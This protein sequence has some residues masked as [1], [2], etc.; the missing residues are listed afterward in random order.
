MNKKNLALIIGGSI[1]SVIVGALLRKQQEEDRLRSNEL[2]QTTTED[3]FNK[4]FE[5]DREKLRQMGQY[6]DERLDEI[7]D[8]HMKAETEDGPE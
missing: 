4:A 6:F 8:K 7:R 1:A 3:M 5:A 2:V